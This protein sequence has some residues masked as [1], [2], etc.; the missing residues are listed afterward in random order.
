MVNDVIISEAVL[1]MVTTKSMRLLLYTGTL[2]ACFSRC[3][4]TCDAIGNS[5]RLE[6]VT[7]PGLS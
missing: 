7:I 2:A 4:C 3:K 6:L 5:W 1:L